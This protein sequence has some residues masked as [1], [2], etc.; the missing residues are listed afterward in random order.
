MWSSPWEEWRPG[1]LPGANPAQTW[2]WPA[3]V[4]AIEVEC[5]GQKFRVEA[6]TLEAALR[7][8]EEAEKWKKKHES[9]EG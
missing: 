2:T 4:Y 6:P 1:Q 9:H 3:M 5:D 8:W 7:L